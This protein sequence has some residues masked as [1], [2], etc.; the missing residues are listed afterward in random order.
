LKLL[1]EFSARGIKRK[2]IEEVDLPEEAK[3]KEKKGKE[4]ELDDTVN[5]GSFHDSIFFY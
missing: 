4:S 2:R 3:E 1:N 5:D